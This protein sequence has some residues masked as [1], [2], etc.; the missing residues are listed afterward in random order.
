MMKTMFS[1]W[2]SLW[3]FEMWSF[4]SKLSG[5]S[6]SGTR[7]ANQPDKGP[8][9]IL[10]GG[11]VGGREDASRDEFPNHATYSKPIPRSE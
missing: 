4:P 1:L 2:F 5:E 3:S 7:E 8:S 6:G 9:D 11:E 10:A